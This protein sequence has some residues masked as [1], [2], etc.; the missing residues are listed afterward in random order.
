MAVLF[1]F[2]ALFLNFAGYDE[3]L[4][5]SILKAHRV[6]DAVQTHVRYV[7]DPNTARMGHASKIMSAS[8]LLLSLVGVASMIIA[9]VRH[10]KGWY[11]ILTGILIASDLPLLIA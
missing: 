2:V 6:Q 9:A 10:E 4:G 7:E 11:L 5:A 3:S 1:G 8:G